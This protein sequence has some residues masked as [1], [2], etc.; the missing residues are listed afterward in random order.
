MERVFRDLGIA[1]LLDFH[2]LKKKKNSFEP[3]AVRW[4]AVVQQKTKKELKNKVYYSGV[5]EKIHGIS[6]RTTWR[7]QERV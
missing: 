2:S 3:W 4:S 1:P 5:L 6:L 7:G